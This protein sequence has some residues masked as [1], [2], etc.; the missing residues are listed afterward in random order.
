MTI[1]LL[2]S[3]II[4]GLSLM[5]LRC[6]SAIVYKLEPDPGT[7]KVTKVFQSFGRTVTVSRGQDSVIAVAGETNGYWLILSVMV[8]NASSK[9]IDVL[10]ETFEISSVQQI[11]TIQGAIEKLK[12]YSADEYQRYLQKEYNSGVLL[13][14][15]Q[16]VS[17]GLKGQVTAMDKLVQTS[18]IESMGNTQEMM[19]NVFKNYDSKDIYQQGYLRK[20]TLPKGLSIKGRVQVRGVKGKKFAV[21]KFQLKIP[22]G[23]DIH[24]FNL[25]TQKI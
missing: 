1:R 23:N 17:T 4:V 3:L 12:I 6:G 14:A 21:N 18:V 13:L 5:L 24:V 19:E 2:R 8:L 25:E 7:R 20:H 9:T 16:G 11:G 10:P 22:V 15:L